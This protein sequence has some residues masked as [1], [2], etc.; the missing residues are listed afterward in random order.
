MEF[1]SCKGECGICVL[2]HLR[3]ELA[4]ATD[5]WFWFISYVISARNKDQKLVS[6]YFEDG[7]FNR[8]MIAVPMKMYRKFGR[9]K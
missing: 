5:K 8:L 7:I 6:H 2:R 1:F 3:E 9:P 4:W